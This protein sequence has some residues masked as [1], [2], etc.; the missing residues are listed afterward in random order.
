MRRHV[1]YAWLGAFLGA[2]GVLV[3]SVLMAGMPNGS[4]FVT[5]TV[6]VSA[7][8]VAS[9]VCLYPL[10]RNFARGSD[11]LEPVALLGG[12]LFLYFPMHAIG[13]TLLKI[14][15]TFPSFVNHAGNLMRP[16]TM[17]L[18]II[19]L[20]TIGLLAGY[21]LVRRGSV[22][23][24]VPALRERRLI[25]PNLVVV[26]LIS[27][28][29]QILKILG[30][31]SSGN[32]FINVVSIYHLYA[33]LFFLTAYFDSGSDFDSS[34]IVGLLISFELAL[35]TALDFQLDMLL[36]LIIFVLLVFHYVGPGLT[37][38]LLGLTG[39]LSVVLFPLSEV[40]G[41]IQT[42][43]ASGRELLSGVHIGPMGLVRAFVSRMI[44]AES[45]TMIIARTPDP[46]PHQ[47]GK[48][49][50]L[51]VYSMIP[52][53]LWSGKPTIIMCR[54][55]NQYF[56]GRGI[57]AQT[58]A[59]M[60]APAELYWNFS[61]PGVAIGMFLAGI[62]VASIY[63]WF[64]REL[65]E[66][67]TPFVPV[68]VYGIVLI[69]VMKFEFGVA[70]ILS[71]TVKGL[72][73]AAV[74]I[75]LTTRGV[76]GSVLVFDGT[77]TFERSR[78]MAVSERC[79]RWLDSSTAEGITSTLSDGWVRS[80][81]LTKTSVMASRT[82]RVIDGLARSPIIVWTVS[83]IRRRSGRAFALVR[84][85]LDRSLTMYYFRRYLLER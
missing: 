26:W 59:A 54:V 8:T 13:I 47:Y 61:S 48:T 18:L 76:G 66:S 21:Y 4:V 31:V 55:N 9:F 41:R 35:Y 73:S 14:Q 74:F 49:L 81:Q 58:C 52:R 50:L 57:D 71:N 46:V 85:T 37:Y 27:L 69:S 56:S 32:E 34:I 65:S 6:T 33:T 83:V 45:L 16:F 3:V 7:A 72:V 53:V 22:G 36:T 62:G 60:T 5:H 25:I 29:L 12:L 11:P 28:V 10:A 23:R 19:S 82:W 17:S 68:L 67:R 84:S 24:T 64:N 78:T 80:K 30:S 70:Q 42:N 20:G 79:I 1:E 63:V 38:S 44:G 51:A 75:Y 2:S 40:L 77:T 39:I 15:P 43:I